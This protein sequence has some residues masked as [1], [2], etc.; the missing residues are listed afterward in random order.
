MQC[1][2]SIFGEDKEVEKAKTVTPIC[3]LTEYNLGIAKTEEGYCIC[4][5][6]SG[7]IIA[8]YNSE[9]NLISGCIGPY[10]KDSEAALE[11]EIKTNILAI[12]KGRK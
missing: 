7:N 11:Q 6:E 12:E 10:A 2:V 9:G 5:Q 8:K 4:D 1:L 3:I